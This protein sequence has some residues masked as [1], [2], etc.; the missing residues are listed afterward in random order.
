MSAIR[1]SILTISDGV[2]A[3]TR[4]DRSGPAIAQWAE[5]RGYQR[6]AHETVPDRSD[7]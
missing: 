2:A 4:D 5:S 7:V 3:G 6:V 1:L